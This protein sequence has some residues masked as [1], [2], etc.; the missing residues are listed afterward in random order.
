VIS[1]Q[2]QADVAKTAGDSGLYRS[3]TAGLF[4]FSDIFN[5]FQFYRITSVKFEY[6]LYNQLNNN[7]SFPT[8]FIAPQQWGE[9][10]IPTSQTE[11]SQFNKVRTFQFGPS[12]PT[13][14]QTF[15]P[16]VN[17]VT[18]GPGRN[19]VP[20]PWIATTGDSVQHMTHVDWLQNYNNTSAPT[21]TIR[22]IATA[23]FQLRGTR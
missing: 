7:A 8:L 4:N 12:R 5:M 18:T 11:V 21:H 1:R 22:L 10:A 23:T 6:Q 13:Y 15:K 2:W 17:M 20:S 19:P 14:T 9:L 16:F 3:V